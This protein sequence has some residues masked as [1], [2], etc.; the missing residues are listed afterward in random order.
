MNIMELG[1]IGELVGGVA[2]IASLVYVGFQVGHGNRLA[3][4]A[5]VK[6]GREAHVDFIKVLCADPEMTKLYLDG[7]SS[8]EELSR[9]R[10]MQ[11]DMCMSLSFRTLESQMLERRDGYLGDELWDSYERQFVAEL[12]RP[13]IAAYWERNRGT[14]TKAFIEYVDRLLPT[15]RVEA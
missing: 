15:Q 10:R 8:R 11:F 14:Y 2:V 3:R 13:G 9:E 4:A 5:V 7:V 12:Q 6:A 1:A